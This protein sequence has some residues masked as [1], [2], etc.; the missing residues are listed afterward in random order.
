MALYPSFVLGSRPR[1]W[2]G[3]V[4]TTDRDTTRTIA[5]T[6]SISTHHPAPII[7]PFRKAPD[8][9]ID[10]L[11]EQ[12]GQDDEDFSA[13][14]T[15][16]GIPALRET[17][18]YWFCPHSGSFVSANQISP[19]FHKAIPCHS[20]V[21]RAVPLFPP[22]SAFLLEFVNG[23]GGRSRWIGGLCPPSYAAGG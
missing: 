6:Y 11:A 15:G 18:G 22:R 10:E 16:R 13:L 1:E 2:N 23:M 3:S 19:R 9:S 21:G 8:F 5:M 17:T 20:A 12:W 4:L 7:L 14:S